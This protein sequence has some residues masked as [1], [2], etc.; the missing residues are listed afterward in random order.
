MLRVG[1]RV[2]AAQAI[3]AMDRAQSQPLTALYAR[4]LPPGALID[5]HSASKHER[6]PRPLS[7][8]QFFIEHLPGAPEGSREKLYGGHLEASDAATKASSDA[9]L[10]F[11]LATNRHIADRPRLVIW[12]NGGPGCSSFDG[13]LMEIGPYRMHPNRTDTLV[14]TPAAWNTFSNVLFVDQPAG[15][16]F[17]FLASGSPVKELAQAADQFVRFYI[18]FLSVFPEFAEMDVR[19]LRT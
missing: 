8:A 15:T 5:E 17:S 6:A 10:F 2:H 9:Y 1:S 16:G 19:V 13:A 3:T 18:N 4:H 7:A 11:L 14:E 12:L